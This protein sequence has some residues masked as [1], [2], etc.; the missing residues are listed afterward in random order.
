MQNNWRAIAKG[1]C[2]GHN[3]R[4]GKKDKGERPTSRKT[5]TTAATVKPVV[6][7]DPKYVAGKN[8]AGKFKVESRTPARKK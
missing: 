3:S 4:S 8:L 2:D 6:V 5:T 7:A 1:I